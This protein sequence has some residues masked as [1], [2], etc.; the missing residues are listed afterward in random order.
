V[1]ISSYR[2]KEG[3]VIEMRAKGRQIGV[4]MGAVEKLERQV[5]SYLSLVPQ[6]FK[7]TFIRAPQFDEV[8]YAVQMNP[9]LVIEFYSR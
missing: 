1:N 8:P 4:V 7:G 6:D 3:D 9:N 5:P 2:C